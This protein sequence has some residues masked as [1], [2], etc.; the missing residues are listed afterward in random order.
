MK[1]QTKAVIGGALL[2]VLLLHFPIL[3]EFK[4]QMAKS[5]LRNDSAL[6][7]FVA[8]FGDP[9]RA[10][11]EQ[12]KRIVSSR[13]GLDLAAEEHVWI[14]NREGIPYWVI[15]IVTKDSKTIRTS[16]VDRLW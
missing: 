15:Y 6:E 12:E 3:T 7:S 16:I 9:T 5:H 10:A 8:S 13:Y 11:N 4:I 1:R 14:Y 2:V